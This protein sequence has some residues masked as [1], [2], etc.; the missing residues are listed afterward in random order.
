[1]S[2]LSSPRPAS[3]LSPIAF[4][5]SRT[6]LLGFISGVLLVILKS[7]ATYQ[8]ALNAPTTGNAEGWVGLFAI[9]WIVIASGIWIGLAIVAL[10]L[11]GILGVVIPRV[12]PNAF[13]SFGVAVLFSLISIIPLHFI[14]WYH[15]LSTA[16]TTLTYLTDYLSYYFLPSLVILLIA[17]LTTQH[18][19]RVHA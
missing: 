18:I 2:T 7:Y 1:M 16:S 10:L 13:A 5:F 12:A 4:A 15:Y 8:D 11:G 19:R 3:P 9:G 6:L 17:L 14:A